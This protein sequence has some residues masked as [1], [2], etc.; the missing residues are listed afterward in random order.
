MG[1]LIDADALLNTHKM[2]QATIGKDWGVDDLATAI[3]VAPTVD[4]T[5]V[6]HA[7]WIYHDDDYMPWHSCSECGAIIQHGFTKFCA[8]CG[9][10]MDGGESNETD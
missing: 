4:A 3:E 9:A 6:V 1:R 2:E 10:K 8:E 5:P 7:E